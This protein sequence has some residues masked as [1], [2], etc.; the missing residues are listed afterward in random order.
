MPLPLVLCGSLCMVC[1][2]GTYDW[3]G[4]LDMTPNPFETWGIQSTSNAFSFRRLLLQS[5]GAQPH[6]VDAAIYLDEAYPLRALLQQGDPAGKLPVQGRVSVREAAAVPPGDQA[7]TPGSFAAI[8]S[9]I[10]ALYP[11]P[12]NASDPAGKYYPQEAPPPAPQI[13]Q[14][15]QDAFAAFGRLFSDPSNRNTLILVASLVSSLGGALCCMLLCWGVARRKKK[16]E[17]RLKRAVDA[18]RPATKAPPAMPSTLED[19]DDDEVQ[20]VATAE[21]SLSGSGGVMPPRYDGTSAD[22][23]TALEASGTLSRTRTIDAVFNHLRSSMSGMVAAV[24]LNR[25][26]LGDVYK[27]QEPQPAAPSSLLRGPSIELNWPIGMRRREPTLPGQGFRRSLDVPTAAAVAA[28][29]VSAAADVASQYPRAAAAERSQPPQRTR[30][31]AAAVAQ[32][33]HERNVGDSPG[34]RSLRQIQPELVETQWLPQGGNAGLMWSAS[35]GSM[36]RGSVYNNPL[37]HADEQASDDDDEGFFLSGGDTYLPT[38]TPQP[39]MQAPAAFSSHAL[40][41]SPA[42]ARTPSPRAS[43]TFW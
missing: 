33:H 4:M 32:P 17:A 30:V 3:A 7:T 14:S 35:T 37:A 25:K 16:Q 1:A 38:S 24:G 8:D 13:P 29:G 28:A 31:T 40:G 36:L 9:D 5:T 6:N 27:L 39:A 12:P 15:V 41:Q 19:S 20:E 11:I 22:E 43:P 21:V 18:A 23:V 10:S 34:A 2:A 42:A 26:G